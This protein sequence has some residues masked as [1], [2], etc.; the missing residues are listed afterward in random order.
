MDSFNNGKIGL[1]KQIKYEE[2]IKFY[3]KNKISGIRVYWAHLFNFIYKQKL[4]AYANKNKLYFI[5]RLA[6][7]QYMAL[8]IR[9]M[10]DDMKFNLA[11]VAD[12]YKSSNPEIEETIACVEALARVPQQVMKWGYLTTR[13]TMKD[14][15]KVYY[16]EVIPSLIFNYESMTG[17]KYKRDVAKIPGATKFLSKLNIFAKKKSALIPVRDIE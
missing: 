9:A 14:L 3:N 13:E 16:N 2:T 1:D 4:L 15:Y 5:K 11:P 17:E 12:V 8:M 10:I 7:D 6:K